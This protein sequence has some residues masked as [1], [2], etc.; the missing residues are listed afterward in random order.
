MV[1]LGKVLGVLLKT[2][3][4]PA[5]IPWSHGLGTCLSLLPVNARYKKNALLRIEIA[6]RY[7]YTP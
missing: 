2:E 4:N 7:Y 3:A 1:H 5:G 6:S